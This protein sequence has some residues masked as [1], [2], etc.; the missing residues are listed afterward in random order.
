MHGRGAADADLGHLSGISS[1]C[2]VWV[3]C[4]SYLPTAHAGSWLPVQQ[5]SSVAETLLLLLI[6]HASERLQLEAGDRGACAVSARSM[7]VAGL[8]NLCLRGYRTI[9]AVWLCAFLSLPLL[10]L[11]DSELNLL[12]LVRCTLLVQPLLPPDAC[13]CPCRQGRVL[14]ALVPLWLVAPALSTLLSILDAGFGLVGLLVAGFAGWLSCA[15]WAYSSDVLPTRSPPGLSEVLQRWPGAAFPPF[16][17][18]ALAAVVARRHLAK[19]KGSTSPRLQRV[20]VCGSCRGLLAD[21]LALFVLLVVIFLPPSWPCCR[22]LAALE[23]LL[24]LPFFAYLCV[25]PPEQPVGC[26]ARLLQHKGLS[27]QGSYAFEVYVLQDVV[28]RLVEVVWP[29]ARGSSECFMAFFLL[30]WLLAGVVVEWVLLPVHS[31][32]PLG[33]VSLTAAWDSASESASDCGD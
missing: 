22:K 33:A 30:L 24:M 18:G 6:G 5:R 25:S 13:V 2:A 32:L 19:G 3:I 23:Y 26:A 14:A 31:R 21:V 27:A 15:A 10:F 8:R 9:L 16:L 29:E 28:Y 20:P 1:L 12:S 11:R 4:N 17:L 7:V